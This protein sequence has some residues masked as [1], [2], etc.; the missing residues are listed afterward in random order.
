MKMDTP[1]TGKLAVLGETGRSGH[2]LSLR[3]E[4]KLREGGAPVMHRP[5]GLVSAG[6]TVIAQIQ[7]LEVWAGALYGS[8]MG[9]EWLPGLLEGGTHALSMEMDMMHRDRALE[10]VRGGGV[11]FVLAGRVR[12]ALVV[13]SSAFAWTGVQG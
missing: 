3:G 1:F 10:A 12:G 5:A 11:V 7:T 9:P 6:V 8:G 2:H 13:K 4:W